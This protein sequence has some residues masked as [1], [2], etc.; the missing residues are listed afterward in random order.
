VTNSTDCDDTEASVHPNATETCNGIDDDCDNSTD[1]GVQNTY[2]HDSDEDGYGDA[3]DSTRACSAPADHVA[4]ST[5]CND[6]DGSIHPNADEVC[7]GIDDDCDNSTDEGVLNTYYHDSDEDGYGDAGDS[8]QACSAPADHVT[9][10]TDCNDNNG[11]INPGASEV[12]DDNIDNNC[13]G[14]VDEDCITCSYTVSPT[15]SSFTGCGGSGSFNVTAP[16][17]CDWTADTT[18]DTMIDITAGSGSGPGVVSFVVT[19]YAASGAIRRGTIDVQG[20]SHMVSQTGGCSFEVSPSALSFNSDGGTAS[21]SVTTES[22]CDWTSSENTDWIRLSPGSGTGSDEVICT[23]DPNETADA[24]SATITV[25]GQTISIHQSIP[26]VTFVTIG[27]NDGYGFSPPVDDGAD[28]PRTLFENREDPE[29]TDAQDGSQYTDYAAEE[30]KSFVFDIPFT[31][32]DPLY[33]DFA[34]FTLDVSGLEQDEYGNSSLSLDGI[35]YSSSLP[36]NQGM[37]GSDIIEITLDDVTVFEDGRLTVNFQGG[38]QWDFIA[39][40]Y[41]I[42]RIF[43]K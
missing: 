1:E 40:D 4:N 43:T 35:D 16:D 41:F 22:C 29:E 17:G 3:G 36:Q 27:D 13:D 10:S 23:V 5:D 19:E 38:A 2:Y 32:V 14:R 37:F 34:T 9:D 21:I 31:P 42:L 26:D 25:A 18:A 6:N 8:T 15:T 28:L 20:E 11:S 24:R 7:N 30:R 39:F 33:F 12:C